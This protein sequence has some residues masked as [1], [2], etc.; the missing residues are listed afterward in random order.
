MTTV[1]ML[2][3]TSSH[4]QKAI[5]KLN[6]I[7][8]AQLTMSRQPNILNNIQR[9]DTIIDQKMLGKEFEIQPT[10]FLSDIT[11]VTV[12]IYINNLNYLDDRLSYFMELL[13]NGMEEL[14]RM[15]IR[16]N[17]AAVIA[18]TDDQDLLDLIDSEA[19]QANKKKEQT[20]RCWQRKINLAQVT[21]FIAGDSPSS[22]VIP[23]CHPPSSPV[24]SASGASLSL[25][26]C[27]MSAGDVS[28]SPVAN[29][30]FAGSILSSLIA[31]GIPADSAPLSPVTGDVFIGGTLL[32]LIAGSAYASNTPLTP[33]ASGILI[34][35]VLLSPIASYL[36]SSIISGGPLSLIFEAG[37]LSLMFLACSPILL[38]PCTL[39]HIG[40]SFLSFLPTLLAYFA[41]LFIEKIFFNQVFIT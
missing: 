14:S 22:L 21:F 37:V 20:E 13:D 30:T 15:L 41:T 19:K 35:S 12:G 29:G 7:V 3:S 34:S 27:N 4:H 16:L 39:S 24:A 2:I 1:V 36:S 18:K 33:V 38:L 26:A 6:N 32:S 25:I 23:A 17:T 28:L 31:G 5:R 10:D 9:F 40:C 11:L 8:I